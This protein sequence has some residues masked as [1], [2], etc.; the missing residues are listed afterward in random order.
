MLKLAIFGAMVGY[1]WAGACKADVKAGK[2]SS[3]SAGDI[4]LVKNA[5]GSYCDIGKYVSTTKGNVDSATKCGAGANGKPTDLTEWKA[6]CCEATSVAD[7]SKCV[8]GTTFFVQAKDQNDSTAAEDSQCATLAVKCTTKQYLKTHYDVDRDRECATAGYCEKKPG[9]TGQSA[10]CEK[11]NHKDKTNCEKASSEKCV[12]REA[13]D[14]TNYKFPVCGTNEYA[15][16]PKDATL[17]KTGGTHVAGAY[18]TCVATSKCGTC[19][20]K[21]GK[22]SFK[23]QCAAANSDKLCAAVVDSGKSAVCDFTEEATTVGGYTTA[24]PHTAAK[25][26]AD[27]LCGAPA[28][29]SSGLGAGAIAG[30]VIG[31]VVAIAIVI[32]V[33]WWCKRDNSQQ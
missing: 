7:K 31:V 10:N 26:D 20:H 8:Y 14:A 19:K 6:C 15:V 29:S 28:S 5:D 16:K 25:G 4:S 17:D 30:I 32:V 11:L 12:W 9:E 21:S 2:F 18:W 23:D 27:L 22:D 1:C 3:K 24:K 13:D 33:I